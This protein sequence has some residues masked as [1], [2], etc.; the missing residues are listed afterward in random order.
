MAKYTIGIVGN[1]YVGQAT[2]LFECPDIKCLAYDKDPSKCAP[3]GTTVESL[4]ECDFIFVCVPTPMKPNGS[5]DLSIVKSAVKDLTRSGIRKNKI[6]VRS[7]VPVGTCEKLK[8]SF[9]PEFLTERNWR[10][11]FFNNNQWVLG[12]DNL[13]APDAYELGNAGNLSSFV[14]KFY[15]FIL[16]AQKNGV[17]KDNAFTATTTKNAELIKYA[18]NSFLAVKVSFF[19]E[20]ED[21]CL[22]NNM[23][24]A[25][26][27]T[28]TAIDPRIGLSH[29]EV[30]GPDGKRGYGGTCFPKD[31]HS[32]VHQMRKSKTK[33]IVLKAAQDRNEKIDRPEKDWQNDKGRAVSE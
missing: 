1:G 14:K 9:M 13:S 2:R 7:T 22:K 33:P 32:L 16:L 30:P 3:E 31:V 6:I 23:N 24:Y 26:V 17:I 8:V 15:D 29:T 19:N 11:D 12:T 5:C 27:R 10:E 25:S 4:K 18:R 28:L 20:I 21:F